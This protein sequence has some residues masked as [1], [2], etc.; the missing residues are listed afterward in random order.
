MEAGHTTYENWN[1]TTYFVFYI[2]ENCMTILYIIFVASLRL[3]R[4]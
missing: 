3:F 1:T 2:Q 4:L